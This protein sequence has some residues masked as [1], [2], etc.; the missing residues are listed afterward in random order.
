MLHRS[1]KKLICWNCLCKCY[2]SSS[3]LICWNYVCKCCFKDLR[4]WNVE[5]VY[6][7]VTGP[8]RSSKLICWFF[9]NVKVTGVL[10]ADILKL[11]VWMLH[12]LF[13]AGMLNCLCKC[14]RRSSKLECWNCL[15]KWVLKCYASSLQPSCRE[16]WVRYY[17]ALLYK[18]AK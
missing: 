17:D 14:Y 6:V 8:W 11:F 15:C 16:Y 13:E 9:F 4:S 1:S 3:K 2:M 7:N 18:R 10:E 12:E 5:I